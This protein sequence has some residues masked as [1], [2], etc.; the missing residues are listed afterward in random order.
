MPKLK[1]DTYIIEYLHY[2]YLKIDTYILYNKKGKKLRVTLLRGARKVNTLCV[3]IGKF[4][5]IQIKSN[6][7]DKLIYVDYCKL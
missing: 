2:R 1:I 3:S 4:N 5:N 7:K 6:E